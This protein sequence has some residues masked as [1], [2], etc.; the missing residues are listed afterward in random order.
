MRDE[1]ERVRDWAK[2]KVQ[3]GHEPPWAWYQY[4][5]LIE[6]ADAIIDGMEA[7][8]T[9]P[10]SPQS[11]ERSEMPIRLVADNSQPKTARPRRGKPPV[12]L[13]M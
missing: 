2:A 6:T 11:A 5:K 13:P 1:L 9:L 8:I 10:S 4:M 12:H 3:G 7:T